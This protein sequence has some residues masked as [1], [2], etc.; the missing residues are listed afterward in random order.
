MALITGHVRPKRKYDIN[1]LINVCNILWITHGMTHCVSLVWLSLL[2]CICFLTQF[3]CECSICTCK[4][5]KPKIT[6]GCT[7]CE[8]AECVA[9]SKCFGKCKKCS[10][11]WKLVQVC[12]FN[13]IFRI[14]YHKKYLK[15][16]WSIV[17]VRN[18]NASNVWQIVIVSEN[19]K[20]VTVY[21]MSR[22]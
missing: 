10:V 15:P 5:C 14:H 17:D 3:Y 19:A 21:C 20:N 1:M 7:K 2:L 22:F 8:C 13:M 9:N 11:S 16:T 4:L 12:L 6:C 18:V